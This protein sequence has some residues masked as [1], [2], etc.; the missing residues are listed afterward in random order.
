LQ[1]EKVP[2]RLIKKK[3]ETFTLREFYFFIPIY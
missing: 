3:V 2:I 1:P